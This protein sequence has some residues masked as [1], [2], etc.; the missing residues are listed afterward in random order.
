MQE[1]QAVFALRNDSQGTLWTAYQTQLTGT[2]KGSKIEIELHARVGPIVEAKSGELW[3]TYES[4]RRIARIQKDGIVV[5]RID[6]LCRIITLNADPIDGVWAGSIGEVIRYSAH[7]VERFDSGAGVPKGDVRCHLPERDGSAWIATYGGGLAYLKNGRATPISR[8]QGLPNMAL[9]SIQDDGRGRLWLLSNQGLIV[10]D[11][12]ELMALVEGR[13]A[14][15]DPVVIGPSRGMPE[16]NFGSPASFRDEEG[17]F[18][19]STIDGPVRIDSRTFP[20][21]DNPPRVQF[22]GVLADDVPLPKAATI[23]VPAATRRVVFQFTTF[24]L[25]APER[26]QFRTRLDGLDEAWT[27]SGAERTVSYTGLKPREYTFRVKARNEDGV[28][29]TASASVQI[30][31]APSWWET[32]W[33]RTAGL[34]LGLAALYAGDRIRVG[35]IRRRARTLLEATEGRASAEER[36][37]RLREQLAH[38]GR[39]ATAGELATS[40]AHEVNQPLAAIVTNA[41]AGRRYIANDAADT[42]RIE[43]ILSDIAQQGQR[44]SDI[45][46]RL[47]NFLRK[48]ESE[49]RSV[50]L[51]QVVRD[52]LPLVRR[53]L[54]DHRVDLVLDLA[55]EPVVVDADPIQRQQVVVNLVNNA[56]EA[57][58]NTVGER[59]LEIRT[60]AARQRRRF[61]VCDSGPGIAPDIAERLFQPYV[62]T[63]ATGMGL[64]LAICRS[65]VEAHG[66]RISADSSGKTG[67]RI[68][69]DLP[70]RTLSN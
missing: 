65:I 60:D 58:S 53:E 67:T 38:V 40:L 44:A 23:E 10:A 55:A 11:T 3:V 28:W 17:R 54:Q 66:G 20:Y 32:N 33:F 39:V 24:A 4:G 22:E 26:V 7:G 37:S 30:R 13:A 5:D 42:K 48:H 56:C 51:N 68:C 59:T 46:Q 2:R 21:N 64:G 12:A 15:F 62:T 8:S 52:T 69:V 47:R 14:R 43:D 49:R 16:G 41:Q 36:E 9:S 63:K 29:S 50:D 34:F 1:S 61:E 70:E 25:T 19:F 35:V 27:E 45:I 57:M 31:V 6:P 18:W